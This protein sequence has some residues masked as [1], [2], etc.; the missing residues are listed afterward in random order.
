LKVGIAI[1]SY[2]TDKSA[3][4][5]IWT[6]ISENWETDK[7][8]VV[9][10]LG[11]GLIRKYIQEHHLE[12]KILYYN[13][14]SNIGSA[15]NLQKRLE[16]AYEH[17]LDYVLTLNHDA[18]ID[19][20]IFDTLK[21]NASGSSAAA[22]YILKYFTKK[23][24]FDLTGTKEPGL[25][26]SFGPSARPNEQ[27][28]PTIW[29]SSNVALYATSPLKHGIKPDNSLWMGWEDYLYGL[30]LYKAGY[31]QYIVTE[32]FTEDNYEFKEKKIAGTKIMLSDK[33]HWYYYYRGRN[34]LLIT[35]Y[36]EFG[37]VRTLR[38]FLRLNLEAIAILI[39]NLQ[40]KPLT[41]LYYFMTGITHGW[42]N[43]RGKWKLP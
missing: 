11:S 8:I 29:S 9:E 33:P 31:E 3:I 27:L 23:K 12:E 22:Y 21:K 40:N 2:Q 24:I 39:G 1:S 4:D 20:S 42:L 16:V 17:G 43:K 38:T 37:L 36:I 15:G 34:L 25:T 6:I 5:L 28:I 32:T 13:L 26:R 30:Q 41:A 10:S 18:V 35:L 7:I 14:E 19:K